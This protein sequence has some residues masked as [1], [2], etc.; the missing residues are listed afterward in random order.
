MKVR[1]VGL[2]VFG[3]ALLVTATTLGVL[4][5]HDG[6]SRNDAL[7]QAQPGDDVQIKGEP[8]AFFPDNLALWAPLRSLLGNY[9]SAMQPTPDMVVLLASDTA[10]PAGV[11]VAEG[12]VLFAG[13]H[14]ADD[15]IHL[16]IVDVASWR[17]P[18][19]FQ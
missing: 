10:V 5:V 4:L 9:T 7:L 13:T 8:Q 2:A 1:S 6:E 11:V 14:P 16:V 3:L 15:A 17:E 19:L 12:T 18:F